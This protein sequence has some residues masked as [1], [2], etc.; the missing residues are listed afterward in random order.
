MENDDEKEENEQDQSP[1]AQINEVK[2]DIPNDPDGSD[3]VQKQDGI[4]SGTADEPPTTGTRDGE[5]D[6]MEETVKEAGEEQKLLSV[7][8]S[9]SA[10]SAVKDED[11]ETTQ[12]ALESGNTKG[13]KKAKK[14]KSGEPKRKKSREFDTDAVTSQ[15]KADKKK[16]Q[17]IPSSD[18]ISME[19][20]QKPTETAEGEDSKTKEASQDGIEAAAEK[21]IPESKEKQEETGRDN[22]LAS[23]KTN[24][25]LESVVSRPELDEEARFEEVIVWEWEQ[26][27]DEYD[28]PDVY[29]SERDYIMVPTQVELSDDEEEEEGIKTSSR[30]KIEPGSKEKIE[31]TVLE[32]EG[33]KLEKEPKREA[34]ADA[35]LATNTEESLNEAMS[36]QVIYDTVKEI[37]I[38]KIDEV[39]GGKPPVPESVKEENKVRD[40]KESDLKTET[41][42]T[43]K[44]ESQ[45]EGDEQTA[46][47]IANLTSDEDRIKQEKSVQEEK[48]TEKTNT[49]AVEKTG[50]SEI[51]EKSLEL[52]K[53][54][55]TIRPQVAEN[56]VDGD[57]SQDKPGKKSPTLD[58]DDKEYS[59]EDKAQFQDEKAPFIGDKDDNLVAKQ[60]GEEMENDSQKF[61]KEG[62]T[63][64]EITEKG[65][66]EADVEL[67][68]TKKKDSGSIEENMGGDE[69]ELTLGQE[70]EEETK[71]VEGID[72]D[73]ETGDYEMEQPQE[74]VQE[75][76]SGKDEQLHADEERKAKEEE[77]KKL[78]ARRSTQSFSHV[79]LEPERASVVTTDEGQ[80]QGDEFE[81]HGLLEAEPEPDEPKPKRYKTVM[82]KTLVPRPP[83]IHYVPEEERTTH[84][85]SDKHLFRKRPISLVMS[86]GY[87]SQRMANLHVLDNETV[88]F[89]SGFVLTFFNHKTKGQSYLRCI[90]GACF[91]ALAI[92]PSRRLFAAAEKGDKP[93]IGIWSWP[94]LQLFRKLR[95]GTDKVYASV[96]FSPCGRLLASQGGEPDYLITVY[97]WLAEMPVVRVKS[98]A[99]D[100]YR[101]TFSK[102]LAGRLTT[103]GLCHIKFWKMATTFTG[104]KLKG[105]IGRFGRTELSDIE[106]YVEMPDGKVLSGT[107][108]G[109]LLLWENGLIV[110]E[111]CL[112]PDIPCHEGI[113]RHVVHVET[114][115]YTTGQDGWLRSWPFD[116]VDSAEIQTSEESLKVAV[117]TTGQVLIKENSDIWYIVPD[118]P[119]ESSS[120]VFWFA[121]DGKGSII[122]ADLSFLNTAKEPYTV[123]TAHG[124]PIVGCATS[125][126]NCIM[127]TLGTDGQIR[128][129]DYIRHKLLACRTF[130]SAG[131]TLVWP[132]V[133]FDNTCRTILVGFADGTFRVILLSGESAAGNPMSL[134]LQQVRKPHSRQLTCLNV[135]HSQ[136]YLATG[137]LDGIIFIFDVIKDYLPLFFIS[138]PDYKSVISFRWTKPEANPKDS[139]DEE[140]LNKIIAALEGG[141]L[142]EFFVPNEADFD[143]TVSYF[144]PDVKFLRRLD[145][146]SI[147][148]ELLHNEEIELERLA[149]ERLNEAVEAENRKL[150]EDGLETESQQNLRLLEE[151]EEMERIKTEMGPEE[152]WQPYIPTV[153]SPITVMVP[154]VIDHNEVFLFMGGYDTGYLYMM[155][156][157]ESDTQNPLSENPREP[158]ASTKIEDSKDQ[159]VTAFTMTNEGDYV[160]LGFSDGKIRV[161]NVEYPFALENIDKHWTEGIHD[162]V[163]GQV[164][165]VCLDKD[166]VFLFTTGTDGNCFLLSRMLEKD[167]ENYVKKEDLQPVEAV[168]IEGVPDI[169]DPN[170]YNLE[171]FKKVEKEMAL[172][173]EA[174]KNKTA[175]R[176]EIARLR[177]WYNEILKRNNE[178]PEAFRL[179]PVELALTADKEARRKSDFEAA[180]HQLKIETAWYTE[181]ADLALKKLK[182]YYK[183][184]ISYELFELKAFNSSCSLWSFRLSSFPSWFHDAK[185]KVETHI[186]PRTIDSDTAAEDVSPSVSET[187][188]LLKKPEKKPGMDKF[189]YQ[190][191]VRVWQRKLK[192]IKRAKEWKEFL[193][194]E[195]KNKEAKDED[196]EIEEARANL[197]DM[198]LKSALDYKV[199]ESKKLTEH[200][201]R[202]RLVHLEEKM[203]ILKEDFNEL[204][205]HL[206]R[207]KIE[208]LARMRDYKDKIVGFQTKLSEEDIVPIPE[209]KAMVISEDPGRTMSYTVEDVKEYK[210]QIEEKLKAA[211]PVAKATKKQEGPQVK[212]K[213]ATN[214]TVK[215]Q[216]SNSKTSEKLTL[217]T[218]A[219]ALESF[220][221]ILPEVLTPLEEK[222]RRTEI[223]K[224]NYWQNHYIQKIE[225]EKLCFDSKLKLL[226]HRKL[227][228]DFL[229]KIADERMT[230][231]TEEFILAQQSEALEASLETKIQQ[232]SKEKR[233]CGN[234]LK[235]LNKRLDNI[236][237]ELETFGKQ[238]N[239]LLNEVI[240]LAALKAPA[241]EKYLTRVFNKKMPKVKSRHSILTSGAS[242]YDYD[243]DEE[244][245]SDESDLDMELSDEEDDGLDVDFP[246]PELNKEVY[247]SVVEIRERRLKID[248]SEANI[249]EQLE[250]ISLTLTQ[251]RQR[252]AAADREFERG[253]K[254]LDVFRKEKQE[255]QNALN[256]AVTLKLHQIEYLD[257]ELKNVLVTENSK[258]NQLQQR[259]PELQKEKI[260]QKTLGFEMKRLVMQLQR[261][262]LDFMKRIKAM[263]K[264]CEQ[265]M[266]KKFGQIRPIEELEFFTGDP[267]V[268]NLKQELQ[269]LEDEQERELRKIDEEIKEATADRTAE[270]ISS[271]TR[272]QTVASITARVHSI[273]KSMEDQMSK[274]P[275]EVEDT[276]A[277]REIAFLK[278]VLTDQWNTISA[279]SLEIAQLSQK[280]IKPLPPIKSKRVFKSDE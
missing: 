121:Q 15:R 198:K 62:E 35:A 156:F 76:H 158:E 188:D 127:A 238:R 168:E 180:L 139:T 97:N 99:Q 194:T 229:L 172:L 155:R 202:K 112:K 159:A 100:V 265:E 228:L 235:S 147:K 40:D 262:K 30:E 248:E 102:E 268:A 67:G 257:K 264:R 185:D 173:A 11:S 161:Q 204:M 125:K 114:E 234:V 48:S 170:A 96:N 32:K 162:C 146:V 219:R 197:G 224:A 79:E 205:L 122:R 209:I 140:P 184:H 27:L 38:D 142:V 43:L 24:V 10:Q 278:V 86:Y 260:R 64:K 190:K 53:D 251:Y 135:D 87:D 65:R 42:D 165:S 119:D 82:V 279:L 186:T 221:E 249:R 101:V 240:A 81:V 6:E 226:R 275:S 217:S 70:D 182:T 273:N 68:D 211:A 126:R 199:P 110:A 191:L 220:V 213:V 192:K 117:K 167:L 115:F 256:C 237:K 45:Y 103:A 14:Q 263:D 98:H 259:I 132:G 2:E 201:G 175:K 90:G 56:P 66:D 44:T 61:P 94:K 54:G 3:D 88:V 141:T 118:I 143:N 7:S 214:T 93:I 144:H 19:D 203:Y 176:E 131:T 244:E 58:K 181:R 134:V 179:S 212:R 164:T 239:T 120:S 261:E 50:E 124:G 169:V 253:R 84:V 36:H 13:S 149:E 77:L 271:I 33:L 138:M 246:P 154:S 272:L 274:L 17:G 171:I 227:K 91:G 47:S 206:R 208:R 85:T 137:G 106:G 21:L 25:S 252:V 108:W 18:K 49:I 233:E 177:I 133:T 245:S 129:Y 276:L 73:K 52:N 69:K 34:L 16:A 270:T 243:S 223:V 216:P 31:T 26:E 60:L 187:T 37:I 250:E 23:L 71:S 174:K 151:A 12:A 1:T 51:Q 166:G 215:A 130:S 89:M 72:K 116:T 123:L 230:L 57:L 280:S 92:H 41:D 178:L 128:V 277:S 218:E 254:E 39:I 113:V 55:K 148:S 28:E 255:K 157:E 152:K 247:D 241:F 231:L 163:R 29:P 78:K 193:R 111:I 8:R 104:L 266:V 4:V 20:A 83:K 9:P 75:D 232:T 63:E 269:A 5:R 267:R 225:E 105:D 200:R 207:E 80:E 196:K 183:D 153:Q 145:F 242:N 258:I 59:S 222:I 22:A 189:V 109:N 160:F 95:E 236:K 107:E 46:T 150:I 210:R 136:K 195:P 74:K